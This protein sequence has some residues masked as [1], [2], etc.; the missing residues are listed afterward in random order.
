MLRSLSESFGLSPNKFM[1]STREGV[2]RGRGSGLDESRLIGGEFGASEDLLGGDVAL[3]RAAEREDDN[4]ASRESSVS[5]LE[6]STLSLSSY[7][8]G[9]RRPDR[10]GEA[11][12]PGD[13]LE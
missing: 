6:E 2:P 11:D 7:R 12:R 1:M 9:N 10:Q 4:T 5:A 8:S 3:R 13:D